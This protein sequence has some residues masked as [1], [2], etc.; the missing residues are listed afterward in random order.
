VYHRFDKEK[1]WYHTNAFRR[2]GET[3]ESARHARASIF[4]DLKV[5]E[6]VMRHFQSLT[7]SVLLTLAGASAAS[8]ATDWNAVG[9]ALGKA[10]THMPGGIYRVG[11][12]RS[13]LHVQLGDIELK[14]TFALGSWVAF[15]QMGEQAMVMGDLVLTEDEVEPVMK[16][17]LDSGLEIT[18]LH[19]HLFNA[20]PATFYMHIGG[21]GDPVT[22]ARSIH[23]A[24]VL[25]KTPLTSAPPP[26]TPPAIDLDTAA[27]D[28]ALGAKGSI[29]GGVYQV[30]IPRAEAV[31]AMGMAV[32]G[33]MGG[34]EAINF[35]PL[36]GGK[37]AITGDF[38]LVAK[39]VN[40]VLRALRKNGIDVTAIHNHMLDDNPR[41]FF[42]HFW[43][44]DDLGKLLMGLRA[45]L[46]EVAV[47]KSA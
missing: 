15:D 17:L 21:M 22:L 16:S 12:P 8:A 45:A 3:F 34:A 6:P 26:G 27:I 43:A 11:L 1:H 46:A 28:A 2:H 44:H 18:A 30:G 19:N 9:Q 36:G 39:E 4:P 41:M 29:A 40:P 37:A 32:P 20:R 24:L 14:P 7:L 42:V 13:D 31:M 47:K 35:Q 5:K 38:I 23:S 10:G 25:S 33:P